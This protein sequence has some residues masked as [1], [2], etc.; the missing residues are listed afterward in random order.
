MWRRRSGRGDGPTPTPLVALTAD[1]ACVVQCVA[2]TESHRDHVVWFRG[3]RTQRRPPLQLPTT[4]GAEDEAFRS[5][6][7]EHAGAPRAVRACSSSASHHAHQYTTRRPGAPN[8]ALMYT[9]WGYA[10]PSEF[11]LRHVSQPKV[12]ACHAAE[13]SVTFSVTPLF[14]GI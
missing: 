3:A 14:L 10:E 12:S 5:S 11:P 4:V 8:V 9:P 2:P 7:R 6:E 13:I 1:D